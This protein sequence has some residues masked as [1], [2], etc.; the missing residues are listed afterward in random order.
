[1]CHTRV[2]TDIIG[3]LLPEHWL[4][5][6]VLLFGVD[7]ALT[8]SHINII[9]WIYFSMMEEAQRSIHVLLE[10]RKSKV[11]NSLFCADHVLCPLSST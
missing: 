7:L 2:D 10:G 11:L 9:V 1:M 6:C 5:F 8:V 3:A 4:C